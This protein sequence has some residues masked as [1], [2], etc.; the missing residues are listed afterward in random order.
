MT[1]WNSPEIYRGLKC[2][3]R[4]YKGPTCS[5]VLDAFE[6]VFLTMEGFCFFFRKT[7]IK[8]ISSCL[9]RFTT[10]GTAED[11]MEHVEISRIRSIN[12]KKHELYILKKKN[13]NWIKNWCDADFQ[14]ICC[15]KTSKLPA[16]GGWLLS[17]HLPPTWVSLN[18]PHVEIIKILDK[19]LEYLF[20]RGEQIK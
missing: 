4:G 1:L 3:Q 7:L 12:L 10:G 9:I 14:W 2:T 18:T 17:P 5:Q 11:A 20:R 8:W 19:L 16:A 6:G 15:H 13:P